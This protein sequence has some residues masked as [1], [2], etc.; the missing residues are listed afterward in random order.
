MDT[1]PARPVSASLE[2]AQRLLDAR[3]PDLAEREVRLWLQENPECAAGH[4]LLGWALALQRL[5]GGVAAAE[6]A[7]RLAPDSV[8]AHATLGELNLHWERPRHAEKP[9]RR[10]LELAPDDPYIHANLA[11]AL[12]NQRFPW[13]WP[14]GLRIAEAG[15]ALDPRNAALA[16]VRAIG[17]MRTGRWWKARDAALYALELDP[18]DSD[19]HGIAGWTQYSGSEARAHLREALRINPAN[20]AAEQMLQQMDQYVRLSAA[21]VV[22]TERSPLVMRVAAAVYTWLV[23]LGVVYGG[24]TLSVAC[25][26][27]SLFFLLLIEGCTLR[28][29]I[30]RYGR[31]QLAELRAPGALARDERRTMHGLFVFCMV[32]ALL[33]AHMSSSPEP[34]PLDDRPAPSPP[35]PARAA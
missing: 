4:S 7:V 34:P 10:A 23:L 21:M 26:T 1:Q 5:P 29:R 35:Y 9:L 12:L 31:E 6:T 14:E 15:L 19:A 28:A 11:A 18:E 24:P 32:M 27:F 33:F 30:T 17:L 13:R 25:L 22:A 3:R 2:A 20:A 8:H 16:R